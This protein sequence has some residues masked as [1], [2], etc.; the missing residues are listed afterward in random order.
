M[1]AQFE[2]PCCGDFN[3]VCLVGNFELKG[4]KC[5]GCGSKLDIMAVSVNN[6]PEVHESTEDFE[7]I[8][9]VLL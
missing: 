6:F 8:E 7:D 5:H 1:L 3:E 4:F 2:C 9:E